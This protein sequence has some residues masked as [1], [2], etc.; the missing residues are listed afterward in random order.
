MWLTK[1]S[2]GNGE[3]DDDLGLGSDTSFVDSEEDLHISPGS[4]KPLANPS[5]P[6]LL[7]TSSMV[8]HIGYPSAVKHSTYPTPISIPP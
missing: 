3:E 2:M 5:K 4:E 7:K 8:C 6:D 1:S